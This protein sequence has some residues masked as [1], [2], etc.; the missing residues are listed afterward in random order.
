MPLLN[1]DKSVYLF[2]NNLIVSIM[3]F[4]ELVKTRQSDRSFNASMGVEPEKLDY[5][6]QAAHLAPSACNA[7]PWKF[8]VV[9]DPDLRAKTAAAI[10]DTGMNPFAAQA[11]VQVIIVEE[12]PN[13]TSRIGGVIKQKHYP[14]MD[15][16]VAVAHLSLA[17]A[18]QGLGSCIVGWFNEKKLRTLLNIPS[19][20]R[21]VLVVL[22]GYSNQPLRDKKRKPFNDVVSFNK[23]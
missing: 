13:F 5:V 12:N 18:E 7:Q 23:Y 3:N 17:A 22:L 16:G 8:I 1:T 19:S 10:A 6:L 4:L 21:P 15:L 2:Y 11:P 14:H 20:K 9:T